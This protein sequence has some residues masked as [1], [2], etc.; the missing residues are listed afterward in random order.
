M[1]TS[2]KSVTALAVIAALGVGGVAA[3]AFVGP[4]QIT[5]EH[6]ASLMAGDKSP[7]DVAGVKAI[8]RGKPIPA[9]YVLPGLK[10][11][12][13]RGKVAAGASLHF[14]CPDNKR[15]KS[16][17][18]DGQA[19]FASRQSY[20]NHRSAWVESFR[21]RSGSGVVYAVCR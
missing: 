19:G 16:F 20:V 7:F 21:T 5:V 17:A 8:R 6:A 2:T 4:T 1:R 15:L 9:G 11:T 18:T 10:V 14:L 3:A 13:E 12:I